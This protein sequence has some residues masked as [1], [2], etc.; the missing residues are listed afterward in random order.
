[1]ANDLST[2]MNTVAARLGTEISALLRPQA[3]F[4]SAITI[5]PIP[6]ETKALND[7]VKI[8]IVDTDGSVVDHVASALTVG[9][10]DRTP[11][12]IQLTK[13]PS[14]QIDLSSYE[15]SRIPDSPGLLDEVLK[16][17]A[18][19]FIKYFNADIAGLFTVGNFDT[20]GNSDRSATTGAD[21]VTRAQLTN[22]WTV[23]ASRNIP[24][25]DAGNVFAI[26]HPYIYGQWLDDGDFTK[27]TSIGDEY[28]SQMRTTG[29]LF[30]IN[31]MLPVWDSQAP[32]TTNSGN[33]SYT[34]ACFHRRAVIAQFAK[35]PAPLSTNVTYKYTSVMGIPMLMV[36]EYST[37]G[38]NAG[39]AKNTLT[40][41]TL[42][43]RTVFRKDHCA[44]DRTPFAAT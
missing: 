13:M 8:N 15:I 38:A 18:I 10:I 21:S 41:S 42:W 22:L 19:K 23:L 6:E 35:P 24:V 2:L 34:T 7:V 14:R 28:A 30:P 39:G 37:N 16:A 31:G 11:T 1:M 9:N 4:L 32:T 44:L 20:T 33:T 29:Q 25:D 43:N 3:A 36:Y 26:T 12:T 40:L 17:E 5:N 27:A